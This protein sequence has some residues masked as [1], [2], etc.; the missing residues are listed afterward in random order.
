M[1]PD[2]MDTHN[3]SFVQHAFYNA[4]DQCRSRYMYALSNYKNLFGLSDYVKLGKDINGSRPK[5]WLGNMRGED[6][7]SYEKGMIKTLIAKSDSVNS[8]F[9]FIQVTQDV[10]S[11]PF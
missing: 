4:R 10:M 11:G 1:A 2:K 5:H 3:D 8:D 7:T 6:T 9:L